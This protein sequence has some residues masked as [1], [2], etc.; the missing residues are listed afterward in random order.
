[1]PTVGRSLGRRARPRAIRVPTS[2][3][4]RRS[5]SDVVSRR[6]DARQER[7]DHRH[8]IR[9]HPA[10]ASALAR[11]GNCGIML[12]AG[13][14]ARRQRRQTARQAAEHPLDCRHR[15][16]RFD[17]R[18]TGIGRRGPHRASTP[19]R[20]ATLSSGQV[21]ADRDYA[22]SS[23]G[24]ADF[25]NWR[26]SRRSPTRKDGGRSITFKGRLGAIAV[27]QLFTLPSERAGRHPGTD[28]HQ[29]SDGQAA[30]HVRLSAAASPRRFAQGEKWS[31]DAA[32]IRFC[33]IPYRRET[34]G[35]MQE[36][37]LQEVAAHGMSYSGWM[38]PVVPTPIWGAE[39]WV[40]T[41]RGQGSGARGQGQWSVA[42]A[43]WAVEEQQVSKSPIPNP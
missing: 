18:P 29:Q 36:F 34:N 17:Q 13:W 31:A 25:R 40:W 10:F 14:P 7:K 6:S 19:D 32:N 15:P 16:G 5:P 22:W 23:G 43:Q 9:P 20:S 2:P 37:P 11:C 26:A 1:M 42:S 3:P 30:R 28:H 39:G 4:R 12:A 8:E 33:P 38:E 41:R 24:N 21:Y 35:Q 27:E